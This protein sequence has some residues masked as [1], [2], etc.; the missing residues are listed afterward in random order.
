MTCGPECGDQNQVVWG[1]KTRLHVNPPAPSVP[2]R[3]FL[4]L[5]WPAEDRTALYVTL[6]SL[7]QGR[8]SDNAFVMAPGRGTVK[9]IPFV[10]S[11]SLLEELKKSLRVEHLQ[12]YQKQPEKPLGD[13]SIR[14][15]S[16]PTA[17]DLCKDLPGQFEEYLTYCRKLQFEER[18]D[19][20]YLRQLLRDAFA[21]EGFQLDFVYDWSLV[22]KLKTDPPSKA[23]D[24]RCEQRDNKRRPRGRRHHKNHEDHRQDGEIRIHPKGFDIERLE[25]AWDLGATLQ[26]GGLFMFD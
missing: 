15:F 13:P 3:S 25:S 4:L 19:Y 8:F 9:F 17:Q 11:S 21:Q 22:G 7:A 26:G 20:G 10:Q 18:P 23:K 12:M 1:A 14:G 5:S 16:E 6:T 24:H 2:K